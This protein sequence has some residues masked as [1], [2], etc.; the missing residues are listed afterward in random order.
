MVQADTPVPINSCSVPLYSS[1]INDV[2]SL[3]PSALSYCSSHFPL[4]A[5]TTTT[6]IYA[7]PSTATQTLLVSYTPT[8]TQTIIVTQSTTEVEATG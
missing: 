1:I 2:I 5:S 4:M 7:S 6:T 8:S 3:L